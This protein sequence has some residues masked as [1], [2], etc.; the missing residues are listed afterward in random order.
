MVSQ[1]EGFGLPLVEAARHGL[2]LICSKLASLCE[3]AGNHAIYVGTDSVDILRRG[4]VAAWGEIK[5]GTAP[6]S[7]DIPFLSW[8]ESASALL[9]V[10][11]DQNWYW[12][13]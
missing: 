5:A 10:V 2:P 7:S 11:L 6:R 1:G 12:K 3:I 13:K 9:S 4:I 8:E